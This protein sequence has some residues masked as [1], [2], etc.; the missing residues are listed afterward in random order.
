EEQWAIKT[1]GDGKFQEDNVLPNEPFEIDFIK[2]GKFF[3][4]PGITDK[5]QQLKPG[6]QLE[7]GD[8]KLK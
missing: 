3:R 5:K 2:G 1:D 7:L 6:E 4:L 8:M